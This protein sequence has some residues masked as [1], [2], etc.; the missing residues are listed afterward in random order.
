ME[1]YKKEAGE[2]EELHLLTKYNKTLLFGGGLVFSLLII[3][4]AMLAAL[5]ELN[6]FMEE[7]RA[8]FQSKRTRVLVE[9][10]TKQVIM[11]R[12]II[13][14]ELLWGRRTHLIPVS[15]PGQML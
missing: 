5:F 12:G 2:K 9:I 8:V 13:A 3:V 7:R 14:S 4:L 1:I 6:D 10:E 15:L 11:M